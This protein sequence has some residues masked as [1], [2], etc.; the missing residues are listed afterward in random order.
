MCSK[1]F[2]YI[3][4]EVSVFVPIL[5][6]KLAALVCLRPVRIWVRFQSGTFHFMLLAAWCWIIPAQS[7]FSLISHFH[8]QLLPL[9][10]MLYSRK[11]SVNSCLLLQLLFKT[12]NNMLGS[13]WKCSHGLGAYMRWPVLILTAVYYC[14]I[15][16]QNTRISVE[17]SWY[18]SGDSSHKYCFISCSSEAVLHSL[19]CKHLEQ[20]L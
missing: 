6:T 14:L 19:H 3:V 18:H 4:T 16:H 2:M 5:C 10:A 20:K 7:S 17:C 9:I 13:I 15:L 8:D 11:A 1:Y 12:R